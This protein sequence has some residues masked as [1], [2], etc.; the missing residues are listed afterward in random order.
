MEIRTQANR[1][2]T[3]KQICHKSVQCF[4]KDKK[5]RKIDKKEWICI[6]HKYPEIISED[7]FRKVQILRQKEQIS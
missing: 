1:V 7:I 4:Y 2:Y 5:R 6:E 3:G